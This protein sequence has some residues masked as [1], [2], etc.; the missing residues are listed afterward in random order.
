MK[1]FVKFLLCCLIFTVVWFGA[2]FWWTGWGN[3]LV[4]LAIDVIFIVA[5]LV[6]GVVVGRSRSLVWCIC[7]VVFVTVLM[8]F[9][10]D[11]SQRALYSFVFHKPRLPFTTS[12]KTTLLGFFS[13]LTGVVSGFVG[14]FAPDEPSEKAE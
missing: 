7:F 13:S 14:F 4:F 8:F 3:I 11:L 12:L 5:G 1:P 2:A 10:T 9:Y 6:L